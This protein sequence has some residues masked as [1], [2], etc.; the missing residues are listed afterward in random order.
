MFPCENLQGISK[1]HTRLEVRQEPYSLSKKTTPLLDFKFQF[2]P[3]APRGKK[4]MLLC[5]R[6]REAPRVLD[7]WYKNGAAKMNIAF[8]TPHCSLKPDPVALED[9]ATS[10]RQESLQHR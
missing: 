1:N 3:E 4:A 5:H 8:P 9:L 7:G 2:C 6:W 10:H